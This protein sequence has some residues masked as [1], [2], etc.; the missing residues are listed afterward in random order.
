[1]LLQVLAGLGDPE[2]A[3]QI[4]AALE[5][6]DRNTRRGAIVGLLSSHS[7]TQARRAADAL[8]ALSLSADVEERLTAAFILGESIPQEAAQLLRRLM[9]DEVPSVR[10]AAIRAAGS[11]PDPGLLHA[12]LAACDTPDSAHVAEKVLISKG[13]PALGVISEAFGAAGHESL[14]RA[15]W[16]S[17]LRVLGRIRDPHA[18]DLLLS[19]IDVPDS[20]LAWRPCWL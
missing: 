7:L 9:E 19:K 5:S 4:L 11:H 12:V 18:V 3:P 8:S 13:A 20:Q 17:M 6:P 2:S 10:H 1:M 16:H 15:R 14:A